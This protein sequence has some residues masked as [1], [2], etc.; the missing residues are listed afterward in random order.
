MYGHF[1]AY[2]NTTQIQLSTMYFDSTGGATALRS[3]YAATVYETMQ[4]PCR[5]LSSCLYYCQL[6]IFLSLFRGTNCQHKSI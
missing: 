4:E 3:N 2:I 1:S 5:S 6:L